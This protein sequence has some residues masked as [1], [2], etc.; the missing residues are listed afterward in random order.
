MATHR[1]KWLAGTPCWVEIMARDLQRSQDFYRAVLGWE[2]EDCGAELGHYNNAVLGGRRVAGI[3]PPAEGSD[4][5]PTAWT[6]YFATENVDAVSSAALRAGAQTLME[7]M[8][9]PSFGR[10]ALWVD[11]VG[12]VFGGWQGRG[13]TGFEVHGEHGSVGWVDLATGDCAGAKAFY[14]KVFG[15]S[16]EDAGVPG[17]GYATF[18]PPSGEWPAGGMGDQQPDDRLGPRWCVSFEVDDVV[19]ARQRVIAAGGQ[20]PEDPYDFDAGRIATVKGPD[21]EEFSLMSTTSPPEVGSSR[22][23]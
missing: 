18:T 15:F 22:P 7:P 13:H 1:A 6:T 16:F 17:V 10:V 20:A 14:G 12:A 21:G 8:E 4:E 19:V 3:S 5:W 11:P 9:I 23:A 2:F